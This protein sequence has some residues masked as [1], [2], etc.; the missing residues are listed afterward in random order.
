MNLHVAK[1][2]LLHQ[3]HQHNGLQHDNCRGQIVEPNCT[4][5]VSPAKLEHREQGAARAW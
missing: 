3:A 1:N 4:V 5:A 2:D